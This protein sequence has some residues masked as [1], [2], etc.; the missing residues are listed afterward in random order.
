MKVCVTVDMDN[1]PEYRSLVDP[2]GVDP[3][4]SFY[5]DAAPRFLDLFARRGI[6]ATFFVVGR[7][8]LR[9]DQR[10]ML[11]RIHAAGHELANHSWS[12]PYNLR[13]LPREEQ[14]REIARCEDAIADACGERPVGFRSPSGEF[15]PQVLSILAERGYHYDSSIFPT[16][17]MWLFMLYGKVFVKHDDYHLGPLANP[18]APARPYW[19]R[20]QR[21]YREQPQA[22]P[23]QPAVLE[24]PYST[25][26]LGIPFYGTL[27]RRLGAGA[28]RAALRWHGDARPAAHMILHL[29]DLVDLSG[30]PLER[31]LA[32]APGLGIPFA[33]RARFMEEAMDALVQRG[34]GVPLR[35]LARDYRVAAGL[36][37]AR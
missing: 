18:L 25:S 6:R 14:V 15:D 11:R 23:R 27:F 32:R 4:L 5:A 22:G 19:P 30:T 29:L 7:D 21:V 2:A 12:H 36:E 8:A 26:L 35:E 28:F 13:R 17:F 33:R 31:A 37:A 34:P 1:Y 24:L 20:A 16:W 10:E 9:A 3:G